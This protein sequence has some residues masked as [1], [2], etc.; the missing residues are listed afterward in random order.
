MKKYSIL[1]LMSVYH[2]VSG[3]TRVVDALSIE[4]E[5]MGHTV[6]LGSFNFKKE[7]PK[8]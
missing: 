4:L 1:M 3:H 8:N 5:K 7:P 2:A 6:T